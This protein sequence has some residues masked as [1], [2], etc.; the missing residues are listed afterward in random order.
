MLWKTKLPRYYDFVYE[1]VID[2]LIVMYTSELTSTHGRIFGLTLGGV[3]LR[4]RWVT[5]S[6][7]RMRVISLCLLV[8]IHHFESVPVS[9]VVWPT[10]HIPHSFQL[11]M[12]LSFKKGEL[13]VVLTFIRFLPQFSLLHCFFFNQSE[14]FRK[15]AFS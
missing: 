8:P 10:D 13:H 11:T 1:T 7:C 2:L 5:I 4:R 15:A 6:L 12:D 9:R 3:N 14:V